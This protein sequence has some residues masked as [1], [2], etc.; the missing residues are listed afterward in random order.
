LFFSIL[1][2]KKWQLKINGNNS[3]TQMINFG[4]SGILIK[5]GEYI[6]EMK[7]IR[8]RDSVRFIIANW[9]FLLL[10]L[11]IAGLLIYRARKKPV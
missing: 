6:V 7:Y 5:K 3:P 1:F 9:I 11:G 4:F 2:D 10:I 8:E